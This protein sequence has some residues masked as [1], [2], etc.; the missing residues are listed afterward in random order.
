MRNAH[1]F[2]I[3]ATFLFAVSLT[4]CG[5]T[6]YE[7]VEAEGATAG[8]QGFMVAREPDYMA[9]VVVR[10][11]DGPAHAI[12]LTFHARAEGTP[13][14]DDLKVAV[15][16]RSWGR[17]VAPSPDAVAIFA[18]SCALGRPCR[19]VPATFVSPPDAKG[20][21]GRSH[22]DDLDLT[23]SYTVQSP[24]PVSVP[25]VKRLEVHPARAKTHYYP[26]LFRDC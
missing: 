5:V 4:G 2:I 26:W 1:R 14:I 17:E 7:T 22:P 10:E 6:R 19:P 13:A 15:G 3:L 12:H 16:W 18:T 8:A 23:I 20:R 21:L 11:L 25:V 24:G 9:S